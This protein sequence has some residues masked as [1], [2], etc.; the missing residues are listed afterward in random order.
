MKCPLCDRAADREDLCALHSR[1]NKNLVKK[2]EAWRI[3]LQISWQ[4]YLNEIAKNQFTGQWAKEVAEH[5]TGLGEKESV[6]E[7]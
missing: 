3:A 4:E 2:F 6:T 1:A 7:S 5:L